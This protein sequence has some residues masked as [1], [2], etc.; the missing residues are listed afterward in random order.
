MLVHPG[1][2]FIKLDKSTFRA[3]F[4]RYLSCCVHPGIVFIKLDK[5]TKVL[6]LS[7]QL[8]PNK[9]YFNTYLTVSLSTKIAKDWSYFIKIKNLSPTYSIIIKFV[10]KY[11]LISVFCVSKENCSSGLLNNS[12]LKGALS[13]LINV[14][15]LW[16]P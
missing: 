14:K 5:P 2:I 11:Y 9:D 10:I 7:W 8:N 6:A 13:C 16:F 1:I 15:L 12:G 3:Y 4:N